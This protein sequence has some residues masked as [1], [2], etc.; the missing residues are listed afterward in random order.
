[1][2]TLYSIG[3]R[4]CGFHLELR[5][6]VGMLFFNN[7]KKL[8]FL[9]ASERVKV[10]KLLKEEGASLDEFAH[11]IFF[12]PACQLQESRLSYQVTTA[13]GEIHRPAFRCSRCGGP[14]EEDDEIRRLEVCP[15]CGSRKLLEGTGDWD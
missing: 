1:M 2:G 15:V 14:L 12:C 6:G 5:K 11:T 4:E 8:D 10:K 7:E 13:A 3:C 9:P